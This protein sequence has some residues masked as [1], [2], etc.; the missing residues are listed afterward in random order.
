M[1]R[2]PPRSTLFPYTTLF[3]STACLKF[4]AAPHVVQFGAGNMFC[5]SDVFARREKLVDGILLPGKG[6]PVVGSIGIQGRFEARA[7][8]QA[9]LPYAGSPDAEQSPDNC[10]GSPTRPCTVVP[11]VVRQPS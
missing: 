5:A 7:V 2:R 6:A 11:N 8:V 1:I 9:A 3:R 10:A 4:T